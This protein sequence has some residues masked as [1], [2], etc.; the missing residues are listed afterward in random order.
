[1]E[2]PSFLLSSESWPNLNKSINERQVER[3]KKCDICPFV[4]HKN[5]NLKNHKKIHEKV[6]P[7]IHECKECDKSFTKKKALTVRGLIIK[8][9]LKIK[10]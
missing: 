3:N 5:Q 4:T 2:Q 8:K 7:I 9:N 6:T 1:M 10:I